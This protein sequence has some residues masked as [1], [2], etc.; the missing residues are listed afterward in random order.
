MEFLKEK[1]MVTKECLHKQEISSDKS[2]TY[3]TYVTGQNF[4]IQQQRDK[5]T[6]AP[7]EWRLKTDNF[8]ERISSIRRFVLSPGI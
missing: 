2:K 7:T 1:K 3:S 5:P 8:S 6:K 4:T